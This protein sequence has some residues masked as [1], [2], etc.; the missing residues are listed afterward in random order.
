MAI[1]VLNV[2]KVCYYAMQGNISVYINIRSA[3]LAGLAWTFVQY[4][5]ITDFC[6]MDLKSEKNVWPPLF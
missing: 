1:K 3:S 5:L 6:G 2:L 4:M